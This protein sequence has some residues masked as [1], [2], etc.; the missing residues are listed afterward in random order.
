MAIHLS[1]PPA[2]PVVQLPNG[3][4]IVIRVQTTAAEFDHAAALAREIAVMRWA[5]GGSMAL[6]LAL[7][8]VLWGWP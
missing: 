6:L 8:A 3:R 5:L 1:L 4:P 2:N 7:A